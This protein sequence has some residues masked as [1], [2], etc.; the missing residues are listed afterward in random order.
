M[1]N[2]SNKF[3]SH[4]YRIFLEVL[5]KE[6]RN[7]GLIGVHVYYLPLEKLYNYLI[8]FGAG[9]MKEIDEELLSD[10]LASETA[11]LSEI[12]RAHV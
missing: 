5:V 2:S 1:I 6:V 4:V 10:F 7:I 9:S 11:N 8:R 3:F 12:G